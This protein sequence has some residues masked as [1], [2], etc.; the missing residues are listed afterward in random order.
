MKT[1]DKEKFDL[2]STLNQKQKKRLQILEDQIRGDI[3]E[4][5]GGADDDEQQL[6][7]AIQQKERE[8]QQTVDDDDDFDDQ[9][10]QMVE[11]EDE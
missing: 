9:M 1:F 6:L 5:Q 7:E 11:A 10:R 4:Y 2:L 3:R 8:L